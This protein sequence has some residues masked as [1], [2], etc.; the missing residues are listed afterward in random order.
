LTDRHKTAKQGS[1]TL[2]ASAGISRKRGFDRSLDDVCQPAE[3]HI[4]A[5]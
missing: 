2:P 1:K 4:D 5:A 3:R